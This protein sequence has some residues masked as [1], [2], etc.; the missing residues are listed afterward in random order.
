MNRVLAGADEAVALIPDG[1]TILVGGFGLC[2]IPENL[3]A[4]L[5]DRG[6]RH[7]TVIITDLA[8]IEVTNA[9]L[10]LGEIAEGHDL[11]EIVRATEADLQVDD[12]P[13]TF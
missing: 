5:R 11:E 4:A 6:T 10:V 9:G 3:I 8:V 1:A 13:A 7:L 12:G 2:G